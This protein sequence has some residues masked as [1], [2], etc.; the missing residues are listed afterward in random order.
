MIRKIKLYGKLAKICGTKE[1]ELVGDTMRIIVSGLVSR[2]GNKVKI[3]F[4]ENN[5]QIYTK[6]SKSKFRDISETEV[7]NGLGNTEVIKIYPY[8]SGAS[9]RTGQIIAGVV[10]IV[11]GAIVGVWAGW[12]GVGGQVAVSLI[13]AG[14]SMI[15]G[16][17]LAPS[18]PNQRERPDER[19]SFLFNS[20]TNTSEQGGPVSVVYGR[21]KTGSTIV[22]AGLDVEEIQSYTAPIEGNTSPDSAYGVTP[23]TP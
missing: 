2:F 4:K 12:T 20:A 21:F 15:V 6:T 3:Y 22:S 1:V 10:L 8:I 18:A 19:K 7:D 11:V 17:L 13:T 23:V 5:F 14:V 16:A 9:G